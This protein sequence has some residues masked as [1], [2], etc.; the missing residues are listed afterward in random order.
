MVDPEDPMPKQ[1]DLYTKART[2]LLTGAKLLA[3]TTAITYGPKGRT[4]MLDR[5][6]GL[7]A[8]KDGVT[9][10]REIT[11]VDPVENMGAET[12]KA[13]CIHVNDLVGDGTTTAAIVSAVLLEEGHKLV[14]AGFDPM[15]LA[16][17]IREAAE[18]AIEVID[19]IAVR[20]QSQAELERVALVASNGDV[21]VA[22]ALA[23]ACMAVGNDGTI[24]IE[25]GV[26]VDIELVFK[27]GM[28][29]DKG[30]VSAGFLRESGGIEREIEAP[31]V[32]VF[33][34]KL[35]TVEDV[36][37]VLEES[38]QWPA[39]D[40]LI[41]SESVEGAA[42]TTMLMND[43]Q[44]V[45]RS[46]A[47]NAPGFG[48][49]REG[50][51][52]DIAALAGATFIDPSIMDFRKSY[53]P[54]W[55]GSLRK[56][57]IKLK[58]SLLIAYEDARDT[59][60]E[61]IAELKHEAQSLSS[62]YDRDRHAERIAKLAGG[63]CIMKVGGPTEPALKERRARV[64]DALGAV[65]AAL[66]EGV[67]PGAGSAYLTAS[68][69]LWADTPGAQCLRRA[70]RAPLEKIADNAGFEGR[71]IVYKVIEARD[72]DS[73]GWLGW[74]ALMGD[75]RDLSVDPLILDPVPVVKAVIAAAASVASTLLTAEVS[76]SEP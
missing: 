7:I 36:Q 33:G 4:V 32:A 72:H 31:L 38:S 50:Y 27:D 76:I 25:D 17:Q 48:P 30:V 56:A 65:R 14:V 35:T 40:L 24:S 16:T 55:F 22:K 37:Q 11:L 12:L 5:T 63:L 66:E 67:V 39:H 51:L 20:V 70:L 64:E 73:A 52:R 2:N 74:D 45:V 58:S 19:E 54:E 68:E 34:G 71:A 53:D 9:V 69:R 3:K 26:G 62:D 75:I 15:R 1:L 49:K 10:A 43:A 47:V 57:T 23:E 60:G 61:R 28:E 18:E 46:V 21:E 44:D 59:I 42:L 8:T 41:F 29:I 6:A 13:A